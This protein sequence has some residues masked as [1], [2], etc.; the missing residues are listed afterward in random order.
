MRS[1]EPGR[2]TCSINTVDKLLRDAGEAALA[3]H[4]KTVRGVKASASS[5]TKFGASFTRSRR[6][7]PAA[8]ARPIRPPAIAGPGPRSRPNQAAHLL[9]GRRPGRGIRADADGRSS[10][11]AGEPGAADDRR[12]QG[13]LSAVEE[14][15]GADIDYA[16]A[17]E[18]V[19]RRARQPSGTSASYSPAECVGRAQGHDHRQAR[20][21]AHQHE[22]HRAGEPD[23]ADEHAAVHPADQRVLEEA[24]KTTSTWSRCMPSGT[25]SCASTRRCG[26]RP[27]WRPGSKGGYGRW[28]TWPNSLTNRLSATL[29]NWQTDLSADDGYRSCCIP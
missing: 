27:R 4:D 20:P 24:A 25:T 22:L 9:S 29:H 21:E 5:A 10:R 19:R 28:R 17:G 11:P 16:H 26:S 14:A 23:D 15:F 8:S 18:A 12:P 2:R 6:T 1:I 13:I 7:S 3:Y